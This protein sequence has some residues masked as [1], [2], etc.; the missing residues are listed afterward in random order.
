MIKYNTYMPNVKQLM[1]GLLNL[2]HAKISKAL[3]NIAIRKLKLDIVK[4]NK[5]YV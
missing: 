2:N 5:P 4:L 3:L 1:F